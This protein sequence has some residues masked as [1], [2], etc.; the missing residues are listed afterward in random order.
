MINNEFNLP[1]TLVVAAGG[2]DGIELPKIRVTTFIAP[3]Q[4]RML[5]RKHYKEIVE[6]VSDALFK[7]DGSSVH[8]VLE[9]GKVANTLRELSLGV[10][11]MGWYLTGTLDLYES[12]GTLWDY[13]KTSVWSF[14]YG[15]K[16]EWENQGNMYAW[17]LFKVFGIRP[18]GLKICAFLR[19]WS[20]RKAS[21]QADYP[22]HPIL[23]KE[24]PLWS[25][26]DQ[27]MY[28]ADT[29][30]DHQNAEKK[31]FD[32][33]DMFYCDEKERW[34]RPDAFAVMKKGRK[35][36]VRVYDSKEMAKDQ[37]LVQFNMH[38]KDK[39]SIEHRVGED[40]RC[41]SYCS[42]SKYCPQRKQTKER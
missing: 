31:Y 6:D 30:E 21:Q 38:P 2:T 10:E 27:E 3:P 7:I 16:I 5:K 8:A 19:D 20:R 13:K 37:M 1:Q 14:M 42:V 28:I 29:M 15:D 4:Q 24:I 34:H 11:V 18:K 39:F 22:Q 12:N 26:E 23:I 25:V 17:L 32:R 35:S 40:I 33:P 41:D 9:M 36:A